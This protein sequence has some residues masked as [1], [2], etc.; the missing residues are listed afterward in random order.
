MDAKVAVLAV[1]RVVPYGTTLTEQDLATAKISD[2][3]ALSPILAGDINRVVG[4]VARTDLAAGSLLTRD[5]LVDELEPAT[6]TRSVSLPLRADQYPA[7]GLRPR[8]S[9]LVVTTPQPDGDPSA[10]E[11]DQI[12]ATVVAVGSASETGDRVVDVVVGSDS[13]PKLA[14]WAATGRIGLVL[15]PRR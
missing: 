9:V 15:E 13:G 4:K 7:Q 2:D 1:T 11:P 6:G 10:V 12:P 8:D 14:G 5:Q 3:P